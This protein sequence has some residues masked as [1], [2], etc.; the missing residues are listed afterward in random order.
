ME[1]LLVP[2]IFSAALVLLSIGK[3]FGGKEIHG[4]KGHNTING[5]NVSCG[6]CSHKDAK[7][8]PADDD[9]GFQKLAQL[10]YPSRK[11][12]FHDKVDFK[13]DQFN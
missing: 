9:A 8:I 10:G 5:V 6:A 1:F 7:L 3:F 4:C 13:P 2:L 11:R 12:P